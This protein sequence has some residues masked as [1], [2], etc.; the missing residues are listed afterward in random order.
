MS[1]P[2]SVIIREAPLVADG[3]MYRDPQPDIMRIEG[4]KLK[5]SIRFLP[6]ENGEPHGRPGGKRK[7]GRSE[8]KWRIPGKHGPLN[9]LR[10]VHMASETVATSIGPEPGYLCIYFGF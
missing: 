8:R 9:Q 1:V 6:S 7:D 5:V 10:S 3:N 2:C 4:S